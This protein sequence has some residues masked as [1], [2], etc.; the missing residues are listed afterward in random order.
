[1][2]TAGRAIIARRVHPLFLA[3][4]SERVDLSQYWDGGR[5][6]QFECLIN[7]VSYLIPRAAVVCSPLLANPSFKLSRKQLKPF[8]DKKWTRRARHERRSRNSFLRDTFQNVPKT[9]T[10]AFNETCGHVVK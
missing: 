10:T 9:G 7:S 4:A 2:W 8:Q 3:F 5:A 1:V 6:N